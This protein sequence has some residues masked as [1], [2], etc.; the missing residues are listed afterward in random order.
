MRF[1]RESC[2]LAVT[3]PRLSEG[4]LGTEVATD[5]FGDAGGTGMSR[6]SGVCL[7]VTRRCGKN[8]LV[9]GGVCTKDVE[10]LPVSLPRE[11][12]QVLHV[13]PRLECTD[14]LM[15]SAATLPPVGTTTSRTSS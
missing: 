2:F 8:I 7:N 11:F 4:D 9:R 1:H 3:E 6:G 14:W 15:L 5:G 12:P 13:H 10:L